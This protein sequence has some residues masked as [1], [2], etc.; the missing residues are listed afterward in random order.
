MIWRLENP[1][2]C[3]DINAIGAELAR[4]WDRQQNREQLWQALPGVWNNSATQLFPVVGRLIHNGLWEGS[5]FCALPDHGFV[6]HQPFRC[7]ERRSDWLR[8]EA[9]AT[10]QTLSIWPWQ[11]R[12][13]VTFS[14][15]ETGVHLCQQVFNDDVHPFWYSLGWH[16]GFSL[17]VTQAGWQVEFVSQPAH[18]PFYTRDRTL[19]IPE[20]PPETRCF[21]LAKDCFASG[22]VYFGNCQQQRV[23][24]RSPQGRIA[25]TLETGQQ[26]WLALWGVTGSDLLCIEPLAGT[27]DDPRFSGLVVNK[28]GMQSLA[29]GECQLFETR[30][31]FAVD[32]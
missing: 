8:L 24:V 6:R 11:W 18:G 15:T 29:P 19:A 20:N 12:M 7:V 13:Q 30:V 26:P 21:P 25:L 1:R 23:I 5:E 22:A 14:L 31:C 3:V 9:K 16:P 2:F 17:A 10:A 4:I 27:T 32:E 28:R